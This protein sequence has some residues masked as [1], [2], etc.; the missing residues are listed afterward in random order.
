MRKRLTASLFV[1]VCLTSWLNAQSE[2]APLTAAEKMEVID[3]I[4]S[5]LNNNYVF[6][7]V[8]KEMAS[9]LH[10]NLKGKQYDA[11]EKPQEFAVK[12]TADL[13]SIS[14]DKHLR[15]SFN[16]EQIAEIRAYEKEHEGE[17]EE[18]IPDAWLK[19]M[20][21]NNFGFKEMKILNGNI[22]YLDLRGFNDPA[23]GGATAV[24]AM[25]YFANADALIIDLRYNGGGSPGM[26][27]LITSYLYGP[28]PV[29]LN[30]FYWR[31]SDQHTQTWTLPYVEG[32]RRPDMDVYVLTSNR[33][34]SAA[35]E[36][37]YNLRNLERAT[38]IGETTGGGAHPGGTMIATD[39][40]TVWVP[41]GRAINPITKT[42]WEGTGVK[43]HIEVPASE[44]LDKANIVAMEK[45][46]EKTKDE[47]QK[48]FYEWHLPAL[49]AQA[50]PIKVDE[51]LLREYVGDY[52]DRELTF[53][54][55][56]LYYNRKGSS[57]N[58]LKPLA[59]DL[60]IFDAA[61]MFRLKVLKE[62]GKVTG[63][64]GL[65]DNGHTDLSPL[66]KAKP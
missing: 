4:T 59:E 23:Y 62:D 8:A 41:Q 43:P 18:G 6:P 55:G 3:S 20:Q 22:G 65:Y 37:S 5:K 60:F 34:F 47:D 1:L 46:L 39:R 29:H 50:D 57:K 27:Q 10:K 19:D 13:Q 63:L 40:F 48:A 49:K 58:E 42:N 36:F 66:V 11:I 30:N 61:P 45:L 28:E 21:R 35:E 14:H 24:A 15:V 26:I 52:T 51:S 53:E 25:N 7:D 12:L 56:K 32:K 17:E 54:N 2:P 44:A 9:L 38:L 31:P 16:P 33:T 64:K